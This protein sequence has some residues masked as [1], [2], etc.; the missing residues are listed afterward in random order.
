MMVVLFLTVSCWS[1]RIGVLF[2]YD[3][4]VSVRLVMDMK[5][6]FVRKTVVLC[7]AMRGNCPVG[8]S[9]REW[10]GNNAKRIDQR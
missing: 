10:R 2:S 5:S 6:M 4:D 1:S 8:K 7:E 9:E 3:V